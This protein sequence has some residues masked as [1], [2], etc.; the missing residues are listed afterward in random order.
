M[1]IH[2]ILDESTLNEVLGTLVRQAGGFVKQAIKG[3]PA[4]QGVSAAGVKR[5]T[6]DLSKHYGQE[7]ANAANLGIQAKPLTAAYAE[8]YFIS[9]GY[10]KTAAKQ[11]STDKSIM[12]EVAKDADEIAKATAKQVSRAALS[13]QAADVLDGYKELFAGVNALVI[14]GPPT[15]QFVTRLDGHHKLYL[16]GKITLATYQSRRQALAAVYVGQIAA[17]IGTVIAARLGQQLLQGIVRILPG[18]IANPINL[19]LRGA[20]DA[21]LLHFEINYL[22]TAEG[23]KAIGGFMT[24]G[25][26]FGFPIP[27][28]DNGMQQSVGGLAVNA[29]RYI[30]QGINASIQA[31]NLVPGVNIK[32]TPP[33]PTP[34]ARPPGSAVTRPLVTPRTS[35]STDGKP[36][37]PK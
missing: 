14:L 1:K 8:K 31:V 2:E 16:S 35:F 4:I 27:G 9:L 5:A 37:E 25:V 15:W 12:D 6:E 30:Q 32:N 29:G 11:M 24:E 21:A 26:L 28:M 22:N 23:R 13:K 7:L 20:T 18:V 34:N 10:P 19:A 3:K 36:V 33:V 17:G